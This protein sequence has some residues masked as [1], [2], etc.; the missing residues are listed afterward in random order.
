VQVEVHSPTPRRFHGR[1]HAF[2]L[3]TQQKQELVAGQAGVGQRL[4][5][6]VQASLANAQEHPNAQMDQTHLKGTTAADVEIDI[7]QVG[8]LGEEPCMAFELASK[9]VSAVAGS[10]SLHSDAPQRN[11]SVQDIINQLPAGHAVA[12]TDVACFPNLEYKKPSNMVRP[13]QSACTR[14]CSPPS[15]CIGAQTSV[16]CW[17]H[18]A[19]EAPAVLNECI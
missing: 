15:L 6:F 13:Y 19:P 14:I 12:R 5:Q 16:A 10:S 11:R 4:P 8:P 7:T 3:D 9:L 2:L 18:G 1:V 17:M